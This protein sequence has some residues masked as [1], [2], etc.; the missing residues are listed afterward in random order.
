M[1]GLGKHDIGQTVRPLKAKNGVVTPNVEL[2][3]I[4]RQPVDASRLGS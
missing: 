1:G 3:G 2:V 4:P